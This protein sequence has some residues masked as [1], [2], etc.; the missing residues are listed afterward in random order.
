[1][2]LESQVGLTTIVG[3]QFVHLLNKTLYPRVRTPYAIESP[4]QLS[5]VPGRRPYDS[6]HWNKLPPY[7]FQE[8]GFLKNMTRRPL[9]LTST[10]CAAALWTT[11]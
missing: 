11:M 1:M 10:L 2:Q 9:T 3:L 5:E 7:I 4:A 6:T 8:K